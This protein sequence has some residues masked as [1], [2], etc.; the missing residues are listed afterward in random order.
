MCFLTS[1]TCHYHNILPHS[2]ELCGRCCYMTAI[3]E[4]IVV[5]II[6][7]SCDNDIT[8]TIVIIFLVL[9]IVIILVEDIL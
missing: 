4:I 1:D 2:R 8:I 3:N 6:T 5:I 9:L 7:F